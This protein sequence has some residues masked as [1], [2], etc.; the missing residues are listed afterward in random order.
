MDLAVVVG[1]GAAGRIKAIR[2]AQ[3]RVTSGQDLADSVALVQ[4]LAAQFHVLFLPLSLQCKRPK[5]GRI[6]QE[7]SYHI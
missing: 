6:K 1:S 5:L 2:A 3:N 4:R 7:Y